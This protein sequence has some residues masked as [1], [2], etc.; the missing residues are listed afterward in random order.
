MCIS[1]LFI[2]HSIKTSFLNYIL[3]P[4]LSYIYSLVLVLSSVPLR[5]IHSIRTSPYRLSSL[6]YPY[7]RFFLSQCRSI[8][9]ARYTPFPLLLPSLSFPV[10][11]FRLMLSRFW[12]SVIYYLSSVTF[13]YT[14]FPNAIPSFTFPVPLFRPLLSRIWSSALHFSSSVAILC[15]PFRVLFSYLF[16]PVTLFRQILS[17]IWSSVL[18]FLSIATFSYTPF[19]NTL[20]SFSFRLPLLPPRIRS[21]LSTLI[22]TNTFQYTPF[23]RFPFLS[24]RI[25][26]LLYYIQGLL[27]RQPATS[28]SS[29]ET[30]TRAKRSRGNRGRE[31]SRV[32]IVW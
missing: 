26:N 18:H 25:P 31:S 12:A 29:P 6:L 5:V 23:P 3:R 30:M 17:R 28:T 4:A 15:T 7:I 1:M 24:I 10:P 13:S 11:L 20:P 14:P 32:S 8:P 2:L 9:T 21:L 27:C 19:P 16:F 22:F